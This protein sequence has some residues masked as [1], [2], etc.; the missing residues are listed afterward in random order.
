MM[1]KP[2]VAV[3]VATLY[4][5]I[6]YILFSY[7]ADFRIIFWMFLGAPVVLVWMAYTIVRYGKYDG[8]DLR[9]NEEWGYSDRKKETLG[10]F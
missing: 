8:T 10:I 3:I 4:L 2:S 7:G 5:V 6:Y 1:R 9:E